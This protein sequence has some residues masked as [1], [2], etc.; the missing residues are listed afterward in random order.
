MM[1]FYPFLER[2]C[3]AHPR[4][5]LCLTD[6]TCLLSTFRLSSFAPED[7]VKCQVYTVGFYVR[8]RNAPTD[9]PSLSP[10]AASY[11]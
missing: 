4:K 3:I 11:L 5:S 9:S 2:I 6:N 1:L 8:V 10:D 7:R